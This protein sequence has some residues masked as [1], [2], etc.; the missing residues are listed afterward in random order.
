MKKREIIE[1]EVDKMEFGGTSCTKM[2]KRDIHMKGGITGQKVKASVKKVN[3]KKAEVKL[4]EVLEKS[5]LETEEPCKHFGQCGGCTILSLPYEKQLE[6][7]KQQ[8]LEL[9]ESHDIKDFEFLGIEGSP[10]NKLYRNKMEFTFGDE[11]KAGPLT[12]GMHKKGKYLDIVTVDGCMLIDQDFIKILTSTE[13]FFR[14]EGLPYYRGN[15]HLGYLRHLV[16]RKGIKTNEMMVMVV[17]SSQEDYDM[18]KYKDMLLGLDLEA[19]LVSVIHCINDN[20]ADAVKCDELKVIH[21]RDHIYEELL[22]LRFKISPFSFF[23]TNTLGAE[24]LYSIA[25]D[26]VGDYNDK[27][28]YDLYSGTGTIGQILSEKARKVYGIEIVEE[29]VVAA[30]ENAKLNGLTHCEFIAGDVA[31][32]VNSLKERPDIIIVDPPRPGIHK[33]AVRDIARFGTDEIIYIS[34][35]PKTLVVDLQGFESY[36]YKV[37]KVKCMDMFPNTPHVECVVLMTKVQK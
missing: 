37:E 3:S 22:G 36:G 21:G 13:S 10:S 8:V 11:I 31:K 19:D 1:F 4:M 30:N 20:L 27:V 26:F 15:N 29:A 32:T 18:T 34:C 5:P 35:N 9:F 33:D 23:Q 12:V 28:L 14:E 24:R 17:T 25:R 16:I 7:K 2:G 6:L